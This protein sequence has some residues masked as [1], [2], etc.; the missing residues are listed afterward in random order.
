M[1]DRFLTQEEIRQLPVLSVVDATIGS[2]RGRVIRVSMATW[3]VVYD[4]KYGIAL[5]TEMSDVSLVTS[6]PVRPV[7]EIPKEPGVW[8]MAT[9][10][11]TENCMV[12]ALEGNPGEVR[13]YSASDGKS[14]H[15][16]VDRLSIDKFSVRHVTIIPAGEENRDNWPITTWPVKNR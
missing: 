16:T 15:W 12:H 6:D 4:N 10:N 11:G 3:V 1:S 7:P 14:T 8:F 9:V 2:H 13:K 5:T